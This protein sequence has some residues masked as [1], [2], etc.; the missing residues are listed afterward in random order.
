MTATNK[1]PFIL[2]LHD[3]EFPKIR[4]LREKELDLV[5]GGDGAPGETVD[6]MTVTPNGD[7]GDIKIDPEDD[8]P[9]PRPD[10]GTFWTP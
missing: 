2:N 4:E 3:I 6:T 7:G 5:A 9:V 10:A 8:F 1:Q